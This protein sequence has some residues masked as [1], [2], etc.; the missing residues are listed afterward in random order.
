MSKRTRKS[1]QEQWVIQSEKDEDGSYILC[2]N[3]K[4]KRMYHEKPKYKRRRKH[5]H[6][7]QWQFLIK[8]AKEL[9]QHQPEA[10]IIFERKLQELGYNY[11]SQFAFLFHGIGGISDFYIK[12]LRLYVE[13]DGG[14]HLEEDQKQT[15]RVKDFVYRKTNNRILRLTNNQ[16]KYL[17]IEQ[18][19]KLIEKCESTQK[20][21]PR[22]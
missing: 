12:K 14:Y 5:K 6:L 9:R 22:Y 17:S 15:D 18:I 10:E 7:S 1:K 2:R 20:E 13:I 8:K 11:I 3:G 21:K 19:G 16:A 4:T